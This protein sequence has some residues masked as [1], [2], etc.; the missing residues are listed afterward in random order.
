[1]SDSKRLLSLSQ[2]RVIKEEIAYVYTH[3]HIYIFVSS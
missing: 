2:V 1:M 3:T